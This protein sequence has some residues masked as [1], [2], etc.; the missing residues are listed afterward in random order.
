MTEVR[1]HPQARSYS[2]VAIVPGKERNREA[3]LD[4]YR[5]GIEQA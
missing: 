3:A 1:R 5:L 4:S 2:L